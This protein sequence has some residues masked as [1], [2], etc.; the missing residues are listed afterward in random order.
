M[1]RTLEIYCIPFASNA[2]EMPSVAGKDESPPSFRCPARP[3][4]SK[5]VVPLLTEGISHALRS[6]S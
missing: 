1:K 5:G 6:D 3:V 4:G 2:R